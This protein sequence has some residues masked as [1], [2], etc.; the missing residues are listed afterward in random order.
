M[1]PLLASIGPSPS[2]PP[3][4]PFPLSSTSHPWPPPLSMEPN[5]THT[6]HEESNTWN[7]FLTSLESYKNKPHSIW[8]PDAPKI[9]SNIFTTELFVVLPDC[10]S[11]SQTV[12]RRQHSSQQNAQCAQVF[13]GGSSTAPIERSVSSQQHSPNLSNSWKMHLNTKNYKTSFVEFL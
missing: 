2:P 8:S 9:I 13:P 3:P 1:G 6:M 11:F 12:R 7:R 10:P 4:W 5:F